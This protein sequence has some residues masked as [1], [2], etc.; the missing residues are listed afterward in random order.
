MMEEI[1]ENISWELKR[2]K[3]ERKNVVESK[4]EFELQNRTNVVFDNLYCN[5]RSLIAPS[6]A[7]LPT[8]RY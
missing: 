8:N 3:K 2:V 1:E 4:K 6:F 5:E 7:S